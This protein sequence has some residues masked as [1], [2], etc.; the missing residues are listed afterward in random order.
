MDGKPTFE[1][2]TAARVSTMVPKHYALLT[3][4]RLWGLPLLTPNCCARTPAVLFV[5]IGQE[6]HMAQTFIRRWSLLLVFGSF[7]TNSSSFAAPQ[8]GSPSA[9]IPAPGQLVDVG[10]WRLHLHC[11]GEA[12]SS[13]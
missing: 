4:D 8:M 2:L 3:S 7:L 9:P 6:D 1:E 10:G 13:H 11:T 12:K 5:K